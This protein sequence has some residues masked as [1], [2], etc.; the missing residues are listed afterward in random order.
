ML[1]V[2]AR[3]MMTWTREAFGRRCGRCGAS[4]A[5]G[6]PVLRM[7]IPGV[8]RDR[9]RCEGCE[10]PAPRVMPL[11]FEVMAP[12]TLHGATTMLPLDWRARQSGERDPGEDDA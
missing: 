4:I 2:R 6:D 11:H 5:V 7:Q 12:P 1:A 10:G 3:G 8:R 9:F